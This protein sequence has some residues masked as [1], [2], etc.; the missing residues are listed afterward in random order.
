[1][2]TV[3]GRMGVLIFDDAGNVVNHVIIGAAG[4]AVAVDIPHGQFHTA[5]SLESG[6]VF[7]ES[8]AG[9]YMA[10]TEEEK[11]GWAPAE[12]TPEIAGYLDHLKRLLNG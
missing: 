12:E 3:R 1:M 10:L 8:K 2:V 5:V 9:P 6:T 4:P 11:G 7:F